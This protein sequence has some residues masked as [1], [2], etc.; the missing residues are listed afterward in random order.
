MHFSY[1]FIG[2]LTNLMPLIEYGKGKE[3]I[4]FQWFQKFPKH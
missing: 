4:N 2:Y 1:L 3:L